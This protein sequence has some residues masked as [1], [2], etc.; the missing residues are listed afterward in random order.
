MAGEEWWGPKTVQVLCTGMLAIGVWVGTIQTRLNGKADKS[1]VAREPVEADTVRTGF[2][3][4]SVQI[5]KLEKNFNTKY[6][7][8]TQRVDRLEDRLLNAITT[9]KVE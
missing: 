6:V 5:D 4:L 2:K 7:E 1:K 3:G 8:Q 9:G